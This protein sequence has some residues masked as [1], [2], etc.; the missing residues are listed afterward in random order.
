MPAGRPEKYDA[1][2]LRKAGEQALE[3]ANRPD[4][5]SMLGFRAETGYTIKQISEWRKKNAEFSDVY[6]RAKAIIGYRRE[7]GGLKGELNSG[8]VEKRG[9][10]YDDEVREYNLLMA[11]AEAGQETNYNGRAA[12]PDVEPAKVKDRD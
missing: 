1:E 3:F 12:P 8:M 4:S 7:N 6:E 11:K 10:Q 2:F 5:L 9:W